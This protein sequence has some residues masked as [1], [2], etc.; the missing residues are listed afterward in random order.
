M[1]PVARFREREL[2][3]ERDVV[4]AALGTDRPAET[5]TNLGRIERISAEIISLCQRAISC[6]AGRRWTARTWQVDRCRV[7]SLLRTTSRSD[8]RSP[9]SFRIRS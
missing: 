4:F 7:A 3:L 5:V 8:D 6:L 9:R 1:S 2:N